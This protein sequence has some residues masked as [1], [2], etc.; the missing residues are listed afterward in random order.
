MSVRIKVFNIDIECESAGELEQQIKSK[1]LLQS[2]AI[3]TTSVSGVNTPH[4]VD[5]AANGQLSGSYSN[6]QI[7]YSDFF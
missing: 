5:V 7:Q 2:V 1:F 3:V 4:F 6:K